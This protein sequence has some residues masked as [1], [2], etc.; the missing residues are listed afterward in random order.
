MS[1]FFNLPA[2]ITDKI[3]LSSFTVRQKIEILEWYMKAAIN[4]IGA[5]LGIDDGI[6]D[7]YYFREMT[8][9]KGVLAIGKIHL[10]E[11]LFVMIKGDM[12]LATD[13]FSQRVY[14]TID[15][16]FVAV[17]PG[18]CKKIVYTYEDSIV[19]TFQKITVEA[20]DINEATT[21]NS[22]L[23]WVSKLMEEHGITEGS[24]MR[25]DK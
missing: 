8:I 1:E 3:N 17:I 16:P 25:I 24:I 22:D 14:A 2:I 4:N 11:H 20:A 10:I 21:E 6:R 23:T 7:G 5:T 12:E 18:N 15:N 13:D 19:A 9:P